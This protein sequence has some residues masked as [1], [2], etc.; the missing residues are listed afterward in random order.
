MTNLDEKQ[1]ENPIPGAL[2]DVSPVSEALG[3][4]TRTL[5]RTRLFEGVSPACVRAFDS[6]SLWTR[7]QAGDWVIDPEEPGTDVYFILSGLAR[8][9]VVTSGREIIL[10]DLSAGDFVGELSAIDGKPRY[11]GLRAVTNVAVAHMS[12]AAFREAIERF[13]IVRDRVLAHLAVEVRSLLDRTGEQTNLGVRARLASQ[14]LR[15]ARTGDN[16]RLV[17][18]PPPT[19]AEL[20]AR[21][22]ARREVVTKLL[23]A[24][25]RDGLVSRSRGALTLTAPEAL[26]QIVDDPERGHHHL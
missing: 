15:L 8:I 24:L 9:V 6:R 10:G 11:G 23:S 17:V 13:P 18:S 26:R 20:G 19:H 22:G 1:S 14:L 4:G 25:R 3:V 21:I 16:G 12:A 7:A 2:R 5:A